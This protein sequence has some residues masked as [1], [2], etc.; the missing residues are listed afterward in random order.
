MNISGA[1]LL[2]ISDGLE[3]VEEEGERDEYN[4]G[5]EFQVS[6]IIQML[7]C[8]GSWLTFQELDSVEFQMVWRR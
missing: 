8:H 2:R 6:E 3:E 7:L 1:Q 5:F 4:S